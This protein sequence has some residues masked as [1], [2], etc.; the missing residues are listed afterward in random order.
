M[1]WRGVGSCIALDSLC[2]VRR[3]GTMLWFNAAKDLGVLRTEDGERI[4]VPGAAFVPEEKPL[5]RCGGKTI[6]FD[7]REGTVSEIAFV[8]ELSPRRA[9]RR[10]R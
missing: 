10:R 5:G 7:S 2:D 8:E 9:R 6:E 1:T 4:D 3:R